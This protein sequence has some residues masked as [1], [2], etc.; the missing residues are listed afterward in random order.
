MITNMLE[1][2]AMSHRCNRAEEQRCDRTDND[3]FDFRH[4]QLENFRDERFA[5]E[6]FRFLVNDI[7]VIF[8]NVFGIRSRRISGNQ[9]EGSTTMRLFCSIERKS[10]PKNS[11]PRY[12]CRPHSP[13]NETFRVSSS[14][15]ESPSSL[16]SLR[17]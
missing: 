11:S 14:S 9:R 8:S 15:E 17:C 5:K 7:L 4:V 10:E 1:G 3:P 2:N 6:F 12:Q 13:L 16:F